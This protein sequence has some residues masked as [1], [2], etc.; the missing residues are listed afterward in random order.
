MDVIEG[1]WSN[2]DSDLL[3]NS[4]GD[5]SPIPCFF[6]PIDSRVLKDGVFWVISSSK[7][8]KLVIEKPFPYLP[9]ISIILPSESLNAGFKLKGTLSI[10]LPSEL[11]VGVNSSPFL[12][13]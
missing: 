6:S 2:L 4:R 3:L 12:R 13:I 8:L 7:L 11:S 10:V 5:W 1:L 9:P